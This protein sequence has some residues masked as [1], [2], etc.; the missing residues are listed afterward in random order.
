MSELLSQDQIDELLRANAD[1]GEQSGESGGKNYDALRKSFDIIS[2]ET[3]SVLS[4][5][6]NKTVTCEV[7]SC[8]PAQ[9]EALAD[10]ISDT[11]LCLTIPY[12]SGFSGSFYMILTTGCVAILSDLMMMGDGS[13]EF[14]DDH[15]D[16]IGELANQIMGAYSTSIGS[17]L[18][19]SISVDTIEVAEYDPANPP[20]PI[21][22]SDMSIIKLSVEGFD[23]AYMAYLVPGDLS[24]QLMDKLGLIGGS[25]ENEEAQI[26]LSEAELDDLAS[27]A[28]D[29]G[30]ATADLGTDSFA[31]TPSAVSP[32]SQKNIGMLLDV[33]LD[34]SIELGRTDISV[35]KILELSPGSIVE[36]DRMAGEPVDLLVN[37]KV[38]AK[39]EVVVVDE[40][41]GIRIVSL[42]STEDRIKSLR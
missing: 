36:L 8:E 18:N 3:G 41:F 23:D 38:V 31:A 34:V 32:A 7:E 4:T 20:V 39:G 30:G 2:D 35:K 15:K 21:D 11:A 29:G 16:A 12:K 22:E 24:N 5:V 14:C 42:V 17:E 37:S 19:D 1:S 26:G 10:K 33:E 40:N 28:T 13:A 25:G 27:V 9:S 6:L